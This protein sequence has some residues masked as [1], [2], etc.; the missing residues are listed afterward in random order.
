[1]GEGEGGVDHHAGAVAVVDGLGPAVGDVAVGDGGG[2]GAAV[3]AK[4]KAVVVARH[5]VQVLHGN[6]LHAGVGNP[7]GVARA[8]GVIVG[9]GKAGSVGGIRRAAVYHHALFVGM[10]GRTPAFSGDI[11]PDVNG[12]VPIVLRQGTHQLVKGVHNDG[13]GIQHGGLDAEGHPV[14]RLFFLPFLF[15]KGNGDGGIPGVLL[16]LLA[17]R[18]LLGGKRLLQH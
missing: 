11:R 3:L 18:R 15:R 13:G 5:H 16:R 1:M 9:V 2:D 12:G 8:G 4:D 14:L 10:D 7:D 17:V 6:G